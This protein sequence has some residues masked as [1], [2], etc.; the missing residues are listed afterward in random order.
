MK[1]RK[2]QEIVQPYR[3]REGAGVF[4]QRTIGGP[5]NYLDPFLLLDHFHNAR[6]EDY[7]AGFPMH[8][9]R[10]IE[11]VTYVLS[12]SVHHRDTLGNAGS[13]GPGDVQWMSSGRGIMH[14]EMPQVRPEGIHGFQL[15]V[16]LPAK[17]KMSKPNYQEV[18]KA[19]IPQFT[20]PEGAEIRV[21]AGSVGDVTGPVA[22]IAANPIYMDVFVPA[23]TRFQFPVPEDHNVFAYLFEG[24][25]SFGS[26]ADEISA[27][28][29]VTFGDGDTVTIRTKDKSA[30]FIMASGKPLN[31]SVA[32]YGPFVMN[33]RA[34]I[35]Q[36]LEDLRRGT[37]VQPN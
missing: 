18:Q 3:V 25:A 14:E 10:G 9:H 2:V 8:P 23:Q 17:S 27:T 6:P 1:E 22:D 4:V 29:L 19:T 37:F 16:N 32:R 36:A 33:T 11:T 34:E 12:G 24:A 20:T 26:N 5:L 30:R 31:E 21:I 15:W 35:E 13:I 7:E 28:Q